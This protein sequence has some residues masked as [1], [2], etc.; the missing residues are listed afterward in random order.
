VVFYVVQIMPGKQ[1]WRVGCVVLRLSLCMPCMSLQAPVAL[2]TWV[3][4]VSSL[5]MAAMVDSQSGYL[6]LL[7][8]EA[9]GLPASRSLPDLQE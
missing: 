6:V 1:P 3:L 8:D 4:L 9:M 7:E 5:G 2:R